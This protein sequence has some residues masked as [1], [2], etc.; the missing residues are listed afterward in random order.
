MRFSRKRQDGSVR[1]FF[2]WLWRKH[3]FITTCIEKHCTSPS[4]LRRKA[5]SVHLFEKWRHF[6][7]LK[8]YCAL[9]LGL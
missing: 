5:V 2:S 4:R 6:I 1:N 3:L 9:E 8:N 7:S